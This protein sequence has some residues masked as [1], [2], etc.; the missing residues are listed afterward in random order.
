VEAFRNF[1]NL[2]EAYVHKTRRS[3]EQEFT[4]WTQM[5]VDFLKRLQ[6]EVA[7]MSKHLYDTHTPAQRLAGII[8]S[9]EELRFRAER[10]Y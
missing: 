3:T 1:E 4:P 8:E 6:P 10:G 2:H 5:N 9:M 7:G